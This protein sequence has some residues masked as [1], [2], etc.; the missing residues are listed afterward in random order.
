MSF[1]SKNYFRFR[2]YFYA[3]SAVGTVIGGMAVVRA[4]MSGDMYVG[5]EEMYGKT[6]IVTGGNNGIGKA[7]AKDLAKRGAKVVLACRD[8]KKCMEAKYEIIDE[9]WNKSVECIKCDLASLESIREF[10]K[11]FRQGN[12]FL[13]FHS[14][15]LQTIPELN[16]LKIDFV[17]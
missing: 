8:M 4:Y 7:T 14:Q 12:Y 15:H 10:V 9:T 11:N 13:V 5:K 3:F 16:N 1:S 17:F 2:K 6:V